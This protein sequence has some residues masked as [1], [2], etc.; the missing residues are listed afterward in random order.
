MVF[1]T[2]A[3]SQALL[4]IALRSD[5]DSLLRTSFF[6]NPMLIAAAAAVIVLQLATVYVP[7]LW[8]VFGT[9]PLSANE[10]AICA[11]G[12]VFVV[13]VA[14]GWKFLRRRRSRTAAVNP[15]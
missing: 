3:F 5:R 12:A 13:A 11:V 10:L 2:L 8:P 14:E 1:T 6:A 15:V 9:A 4:A 7:F